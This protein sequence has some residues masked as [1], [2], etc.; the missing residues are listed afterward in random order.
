VCMLGVKMISTVEHLHSKGLL[1]R[2]IKPGNFVM[3]RGVHGN[4]LYL[5]D[6][7]L[8]SPY[9]DDNGKH[10]G[11]ST[12]ARFHGTDKYASISNHKKLEPGRRDDMESLGYLL[13]YFLTGNLPWSKKYARVKK[14]TEGIC[15]ENARCRLQSKS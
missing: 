14:N 13:V 3:G 1:H 9:I 4:D 8:A 7:G 12:D 10:I 2:D 5:I 6:Y 15:T 11:F